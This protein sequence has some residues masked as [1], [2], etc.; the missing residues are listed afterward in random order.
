[1]CRPRSTYFSISKVSSPKAASDSRRA[2]ATASGSSAAAPD[3]PHSLS[4]AAGRRLHQQ[5]KTDL[6]GGPVGQ[7]VDRQFVAALHRRQHRHTGRNRHSAGNVLASQQVDDL[8]RW[9]D[10]NQ[11]VLAAGAGERCPLGE[12]SVTGVNRIGA[13]AP[14]GGQQG[15]DRQVRLRRRSGTDAFGGVGRAHVR[16]IGVGIGIHRN[17]PQPRRP[18]GPDDPQGDLAPVGHQQGGERRLRHGPTS[19]RCRSSASGSAPAR[20]APAPC[21]PPGGYPPDR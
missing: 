11:A 21:R 1:M 12:K 20:P 9:S 16:R 15:R 3:D 5:R 4:T 14:G 19:G 10:E 6:G 18:G 8:C 7:F 2:D 17:R 13:T